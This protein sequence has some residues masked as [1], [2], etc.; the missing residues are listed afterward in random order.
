MRD[1]DIAPIL[2]LILAGIIIF[3]VGFGVGVEAGLN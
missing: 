3:S 2:I 1:E